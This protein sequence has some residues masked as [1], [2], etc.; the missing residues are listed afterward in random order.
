MLRLAARRAD[1]VASAANPSCARD[2]EAG[3]RPDGQ[4]GVAAR[5]ETAEQERVDL[6]GGGRAGTTRDH[7]EARADQGARPA[8]LE[9]W[10]C[11]A[12]SILRHRRIILRQS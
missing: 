11:S 4:E 6:A 2:V 10:R 9:R 7:G 12:R 8:I 3:L 5:V 1:A